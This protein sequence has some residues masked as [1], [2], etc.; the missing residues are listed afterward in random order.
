[1]EA[2]RKQTEVTD[3][4]LAHYRDDLA[5]AKNYAESLHRQQQQQRRRFKLECTAAVLLS[6]AVL[7]F[8]LW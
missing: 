6:S 5:A 4:E 1:M 8:L 2:K 3:R 7:V